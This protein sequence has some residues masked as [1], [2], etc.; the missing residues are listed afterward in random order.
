MTT[1]SFGISGTSSPTEDTYRSTTAQPGGNDVSADLKILGKANA[2]N[3][4]DLLGINIPLDFG[5]DLSFS[6]VSAQFDVSQ[7]RLAI[8]MQ[9]WLERNMRAGNRYI[10]FLLA[11]FGIAPNDARLQRPE[12]IGGTKSPIISSEVLQTSA[13]VEGQTK[14]G[15]MAGHGISADK[16]QATNYAV[17]ENGVIMCITSVLPR[18]VYSQGVN[19]QW[20]R[21]SR[22]D[23]YS[24]EFAHLTEQMV[25]SGELY[26]DGN[27]AENTSE[28][29]FQGRFNE[30]RYIRIDLVLKC[31]IPLLIII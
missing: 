24:P 22:Y 6:T 18:T 16:T 11:H 30:L 8:Q 15:T 20:L 12:Y 13:T 9:K 29:G 31:V 28:F 27:Q 26:A 10:E 2:G 4:N 17:K 19:R 5:K 23:F 7:L 3:Y 21:R 1:R 25:L 14:L